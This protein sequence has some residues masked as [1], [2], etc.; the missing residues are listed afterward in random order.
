MRRRQGGK[1]RVVVKG[2]GVADQ[3]AGGRTLEAHVQDTRR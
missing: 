1:G 2:R 3:R